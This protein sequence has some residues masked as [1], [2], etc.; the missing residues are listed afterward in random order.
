MKRGS[1]ILAL[2]LALTFTACSRETKEAEKGVPEVYSEVAE[3]QA[4]A[5]VDLGLSEKCLL[6]AKGDLDDYLG[7]KGAV[8]AQ[9]YG[10]DN[11]G[12]L[13]DFG[14]VQSDGSGY[15]LKVETPYLYVCG[16]HDIDL[17][18]PNVE[19][20]TLDVYEGA[21]IKFGETT[22]TFFYTKDGV[23]KEVE[24][25]TEFDNLL[26]RYSDKAELIDFGSNK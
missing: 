23:E 26:E 18:Y 25:M 16:G 19:T 17:L 10:V 6:I 14:E 1:I 12:N 4:Y 22:D 20:G 15:L 13:V 24:D 21:R 3:G 8:T 9:V 7:K 5:L 2:A 11:E